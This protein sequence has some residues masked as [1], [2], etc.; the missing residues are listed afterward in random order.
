MTVSQD[1]PTIPPLVVQAQGMWQSSIVTEMLHVAADRGVFALL[2][3]GP[4]TSSELAD[5]TGT[6]ER[7]LHRLLR[8]MV[9]L[10]LCSDTP[11]GWTLTPLGTAAAQLA[12][13]ST[14]ALPTIPE[15]GRAVETGRPAMTFS[16]GC[17]LFE[18]FE[19]HPGDGAEFDAR[20][21]VVN[22]EEP[23]AV[24]E[25][26]PFAGV[27]RLVD[28]GGGNG[29]FLAEVL[30]SQPS[31]QGVLFDLP[32]TIAHPSAELSPVAE[33]CQITAGDFFESVPA[34]ADA[35]LLSHV[36]HDWPE[37]QAL[38]ILTRVREAIAPSGRLLIVELVMPT[39]DT[40]HPARMI[41]IVMLLFT[42]GEER[43]GDEYADLLARAGFRLERVIPTRSPVSIL[44][45]VPV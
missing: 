32:R 26:Y 9:G 3:D 18:Y 41:D 40:P 22:A 1:A 13:P 39:D 23:R 20:L 31:L 12:G 15:L 8:S 38:S 5:A 17:T 34:G 29:A 21:A 28:V 37:P 2:L 16:H 33:R 35:Y 30:R 43:T 45:A 6:H 44:E 4:R 19:R 11:R 24:T 7:S 10:G 42:G 36:I 27:E 25:A 14:W